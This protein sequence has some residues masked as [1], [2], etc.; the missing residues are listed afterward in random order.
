MEVKTY[1]I[2]GAPIV[3]RLKLDRLW[4]TREENGQVSVSTPVRDPDN[5]ED[6]YFLTMT[7]SGAA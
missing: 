6:V 4:L 7:L 3:A 2:E 5:V 1:E